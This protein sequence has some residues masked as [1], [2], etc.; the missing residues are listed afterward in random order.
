MVVKRIGGLAVCVLMTAVGSG[1]RMRAPVRDVP[2]PDRAEVHQALTDPSADELALR[3][4]LRR[5]GEAAHG[6]ARLHEA[7]R[8]LAQHALTPA[9]AAFEDALRFI[10][11]RETGERERARRGLA[12]AWYRQAIAF[13]RAG[14]FEQALA[15]AVM[16]R[17][18]GYVKADSLIRRIHRRL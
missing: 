9:I 3:E 7:E 2:E 6:R 11:P 12:D 8:L 18:H 4:R 15:A 10:P 13:E 1:C 16:A 5:E 17:N 14:D